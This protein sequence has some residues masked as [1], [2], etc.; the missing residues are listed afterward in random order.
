MPSVSNWWVATRLR[1]AEQVERNRGVVLAAAKRVFLARGYAG[2]SVEAISEEAGF[3][4]GVVYSQFGSKA[5]MFLALLDRRIDERT[6]ENE[7]VVGDLVGVDAVRALLAAAARDGTAEP[8]W[9][10]LLVEFRASAGRDPELNDRYA[11]A[12]GRTVDA[13]VAVLDGI[14]QRAGRE[15]AVPLRSMAEFVVGL[16]PAVALERLANPGALTDT[17]L[18]AMVIRALGLPES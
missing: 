3:S 9:A 12:H 15:P 13:L 8:G 18:T 11:E 6:A 4:K 10:R 16:G 17:D 1:R 5:D 2:A 7:R 14:H